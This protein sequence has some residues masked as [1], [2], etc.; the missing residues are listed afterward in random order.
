[1]IPRFK[2]EM[3]QRRRAAKKIEHS[4]AKVSSLKILVVLVVLVAI[5]SAVAC[6]RAA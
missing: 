4:V 3:P 2:I 1:M 5:T 6:G